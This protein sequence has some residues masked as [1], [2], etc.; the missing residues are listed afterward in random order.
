MSTLAITVQNESGTSLEN[1]TINCEFYIQYNNTSTSRIMNSGVLS[2]LVGSTDSKGVSALSSERITTSKEF[3]KYWELY[4]NNVKKGQSGK[5]YIISNTVSNATK[6]YATG[7]ETVTFDLGAQSGKVSK[8]EKTGYY[9]IPELSGN[10]PLTLIASDSSKVNLDTL[11]KAFKEKEAAYL[12]AKRVYEENLKVS[13]TSKIFEQL[14][15]Y[16]P[17]KWANVITRLLEFEESTLDAGLRFAKKTNLTEEFN[18]LDIIKTSILYLK[19]LY[20][21]IKIGDGEGVP[22]NK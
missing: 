5:F 16:E 11:E 14:T 15:T 17:A 18:R 9:T 3:T 6:G 8:D 10:K 4:T 13:D 2:E 1:I 12:Q 21:D 7:F 20:P 22:Y 19:N